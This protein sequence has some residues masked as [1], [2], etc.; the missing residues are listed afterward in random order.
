MNRL[1][2]QLMVAS[3]VVSAVASTTTMSLASFTNPL[4]PAWRGSE[5]TSYLYWESFTSAFEGTNAP[6]TSTG[7]WGSNLSNSLTGA[8]IAGSGNMYGAGGAM[9]IGISA[10]SAPTNMGALVLNISTA[11]TEIDYGAVGLTRTLVGGEIQ[12]LAFDSYEIRF[13]SAIPNFGN[14]INVAYTWDLSAIAGDAITGW[15]ISFASPIANMSLDA[16][17][18]DINTVP[19]PSAIALLGCVGLLRRRAR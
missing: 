17:S 9:S 11:G 15:N 10:T 12:T 6:Q 8:I 4:V 18:V 16:V 19:A 13:T 5:G 1:S 3:A 2:A 14:M 7:V